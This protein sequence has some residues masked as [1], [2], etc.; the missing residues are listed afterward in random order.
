MIHLKLPSNTHPTLP[1]EGGLREGV[2]LPFYLAMEEW[3]AKKLPAGEYFFIWRVSPTVICGR[4]QE[5]DKEVDMAYCREA[6]ID[7]VRRKSGGGCVYADM[8]NFMLSYVC[9]GDEVTATFASYTT[10]VANML[11][12]LGV[13]A[14]ATGR[15]DIV[16]NGKKVSGNAF[17]HL[18]GRCIAHGTMLY[19]F[20]PS[21]MCRAITPSRAKM[22][23]KAVK[24]VESRVT[25]LCKE[26][27]AIPKEEFESRIVSALC[28]SEIVLT[29][30]DIAEIK[31]IEQ[32]YY[33]PEFLYRKGELTAQT[34]ENIDTPNTI[35]L[36]GRVE[37]VGEINFAIVLDDDGL[38]SRIEVSGD[39][40]L[41]GD[42][43]EHIFRH[44]KGHP[45]TKET[46]EKALSH[47]APEK[48]IAS[49]TQASLEAILFP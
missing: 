8:D 22:E 47:T 43:E 20:D 29:D 44:L 46:I 30:K 45:F 39:F 40:F 9:P 36:G 34:P 27:I 19:D 26:G 23:S 37:G 10:M 2:R 28:D 35:R 13:E 49:L 7:V 1:L 16:I 38:I 32:T 25:C 3:A 6:G 15:N 41:T 12:E 14:S 21:V 18:P 31:E 4:N 42:P 11:R 17:Y 33:A 48:A 24:S 5:M